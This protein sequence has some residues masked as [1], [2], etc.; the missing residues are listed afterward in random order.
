MRVQLIAARSFSSIQ[1][2]QNEGSRRLA[3]LWEQAQ[4]YQLDN[5]H[6]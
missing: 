6:D 5:V 3:D 4:E 2:V 1:A